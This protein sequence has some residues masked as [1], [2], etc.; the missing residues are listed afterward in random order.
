VTVGARWWP[1]VLTQFSPPPASIRGGSLVTS[2]G[3]HARTGSVQLMVSSG[4]RR[5]CATRKHRRLA[6]ELV[7]PVSPQPLAQLVAHMLGEAIKRSRATPQT[8]QPSWCIGRMAQLLP[9]V[10]AHRRTGDRT[11]VAAKPHGPTIEATVMMVHVGN[12]TMR[13]S[14]GALPRSGTLVYTVQ[15]LACYTVRH[16]RSLAN[17]RGGLWKSS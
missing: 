8:D 10:V 3:P 9:A 13:D 15:R 14:L 5:R 12:S 7:R 11:V 16:N 4:W 2:T 6:S 1:M 17:V